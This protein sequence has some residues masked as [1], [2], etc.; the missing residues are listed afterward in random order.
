[1]RQSWVHR[2]TFSPPA[3]RPPSPS[4]SQRRLQAWP[5]HL[6][7]LSQ[8]T[9]AFGHHCKEA[10][11]GIMAA[12]LAA[13]WRPICVTHQ[14]NLFSEVIFLDDSVQRYAGGLQVF[15]VSAQLPSWPVPTGSC[16]NRPPGLGS[17]QQEALRVGAGNQRT[18]RSI[19]DPPVRHGCQHTGSQ[20]R[21]QCDLGV[22][23]SAH[24][25]PSG[26]TQRPG[27]HLTE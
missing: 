10:S 8:G 26:C 3:R 12:Q 5:P 2:S 20:G 14:P 9:P 24:F 1:M 22:A 19:P 18:G 16:R 7:A 13:D 23:V 15:P 17:L 25:L 27:C 4:E 6:R 21:R 11:E